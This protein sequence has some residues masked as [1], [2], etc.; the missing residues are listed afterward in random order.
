MGDGSYHM[1]D[2]A[3]TA[4]WDACEPQALLA[5]PFSPSRLAFPLRLAHAGVKTPFS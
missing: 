5:R 2:A 1:A 3:V 4:G